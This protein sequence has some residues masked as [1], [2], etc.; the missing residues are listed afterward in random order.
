MANSKKDKEGYIDE[1]YILNKL[2]RTH[3]QDVTLTPDFVLKEKA[4]ITL[5]VAGVFLA[6]FYLFNSL[7]GFFNLPVQLVLLIGAPLLSFAATVYLTFYGRSTF[8]S[9]LSGVV[10]LASFV[11]NLSALVTLFTVM[12][13]SLPLLVWALFSVFLY[14]MCHSRIFLVSGLVFT[15]LLFTFLSN[16]EY[17]YNW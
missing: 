1:D 13:S 10:C 2:E 3:D 12:P 15:G 5:I 4:R 16:I 11:V 6:V 9:K 14:F 8:L 17:I 7:W